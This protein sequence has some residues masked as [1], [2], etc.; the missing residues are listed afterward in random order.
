MRN[1]LLILSICSTTMLLPACATVP[2]PA[3]VC[4]SEWISPRANRAM[5]EFKNDARPV[6]RKL[7]KIGKKLESGGSF[8]PLAMFSLMNSLQNLGNKLEHGRAM[9]DMRTLATTCNDP[10]LIKNAM[11]DFLRE[12]GIDEKFINFLNNFEAYTQL[13]ETGE[14]PDI[15]L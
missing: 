13:L 8:K 1:S 3:E 4:S 12:Q 5:A 7:R 2:E 14:R 11:T 9:R 6:V 10:T 15:K